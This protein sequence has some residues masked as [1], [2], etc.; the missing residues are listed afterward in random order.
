MDK[1]DLR[2]QFLPDLSAEATLKKAQD[3]LREMARREKMVKPTGILAEIDAL[4]ADN[5]D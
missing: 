5:T 1:I 3:N 2:K 4:R